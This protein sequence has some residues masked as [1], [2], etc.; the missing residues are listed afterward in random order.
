MT[1]EWPEVKTDYPLPAPA[2]ELAFEIA[3]SIEFREHWE[4][5]LTQMVPALVS[6]VQ[7]ATSMM[8]PAMQGMIP[9]EVREFVTVAEK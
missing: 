6:I 7:L 3:K 8:P 4:P 1:I 5:I 2:E 9:P